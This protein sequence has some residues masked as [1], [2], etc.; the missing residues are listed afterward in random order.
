MTY[1]DM[2]LTRTFENSS[3]EEKKEILKAG[4]KGFINI[5]KSNEEY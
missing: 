3:D 5:L 1:L 2:I 4:G